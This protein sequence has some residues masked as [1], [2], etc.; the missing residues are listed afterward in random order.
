MPLTLR[1]EKYQRQKLMEGVKPTKDA[2]QQENFKFLQS[3][4]FIQRFEDEVEEANEH[5]RGRNF[6]EF[7]KDPLGEEY[8]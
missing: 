7:K 3:L 5:L 2:V 6:E 8:I 1:I 4:K